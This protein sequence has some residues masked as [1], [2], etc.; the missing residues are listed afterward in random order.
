MDPASNQQIAQE[1]RER[2][3]ELARWTQQ[4]LVNRTDVW[5]RYAGKKSGANRAYQAITAPFSQ[6]RGKVFLGESSLTKHFKARD[7]RGVLGLHSIG[8]QLSSRWFAIDIDRHDEDDLSITAEGNYVVA[9]GW[10]EK[11]SKMGF[12][13]LLFDSNG[14]GGYHILTIFAEPMATKSVRAFAQE[15]TSDFERRGLD[16]P[17]EIFPGNPKWDHY[18]DWL[19]LFGR[20]H[21]R[22]HYTRVWNDEPWAEDTWLVGHDAIDRI[23]ATRP[24]PLELLAKHG[25]EQV[26]STICLDFDGVIHSYKSGWCG[27]GVIP[28][29]P[30]HGTRTAIERLRKSFRVVVHSARCHSEE[31]RKA[32]A[33]W[34]AKHD[35]VVD[36]ICENKPPAMVYVDDR[37]VQFRG[38]WNDAIAAIHE[39]RR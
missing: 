26:R 28:D 12:D 37:A 14:V 11:L 29:E 23:L 13:P 16:C 6:E 22:S 20:H 24:A 5:G 4:H 39:F 34:L 7:G 36:E 19:R 21:Y 31:G 27:A 17:P 32:I 35:I 9:H 38:E 3:P 15:V 18:G 10:W 30:V 25:I 33:D 2:A 1:W 8:P